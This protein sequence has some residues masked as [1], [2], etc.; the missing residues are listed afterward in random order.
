MKLIKHYILRHRLT[1]N[2]IKRI[3]RRLKKDDKRPFIF[4]LTEELWKERE[5]IFNRINAQFPCIEIIGDWTEYI[6]EI[7]V[8]FHGEE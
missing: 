2:V 7:T 4:Y 1:K 3:R 8:L 5:Y 6:G